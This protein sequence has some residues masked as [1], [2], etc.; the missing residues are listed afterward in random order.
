MKTDGYI[1]NVL[2]WLGVPNTVKNKSFFVIS[3]GN[4]IIYY[5]ILFISM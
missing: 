2:F 4:K 3:Y 1:L 5:F